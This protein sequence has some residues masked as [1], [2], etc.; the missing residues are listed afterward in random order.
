[1]NKQNIIIMT[2][3]WIV[4]FSSFAAIRFV[5]V[6]DTQPMPWTTI[7][8]NV[9]N[10]GTSSAQAYRGDWGNT[11]SNLAASALSTNGGTM[12]ANINLNGNTLSNG[13]VSASSL[14]VTGLSG[15]GVVPVGA[16]Q[17][18]VATNPPGGWLN[19]NGNSVETNTYPALFAVIST[20]F[21]STNAAWFNLPNFNGRFPLGASSGLGVTSGVSSV[22]LTTNQMPVHTHLQNIHDHQSALYNGV[23]TGDGPARGANPAQVNYNISVGSAAGTTAVNQNAGGGLPHT[24]MPPN[25]TI[26]YIIKY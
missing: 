10:I 23:G 22:T 21:G 11:A 20:N 12:G 26:N 3:C 6:D 16:V 17:M 1:M 13:A 2:F 15:N 14:Q 9:T 25:L 19:C 24:N 4:L 8:G 7:A 18:Y 5:Q